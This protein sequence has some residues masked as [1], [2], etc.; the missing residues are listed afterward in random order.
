VTELCDLYLADAE[1]GRLLTQRK[2]SKKP[3]TLATDR[4][5]IERHIKLLL[6]RLAALCCTIDQ[7]GVRNLQN[8]LKSC[9]ERYLVG[10]LQGKDDQEVGKCV[11]ASPKGRGLFYPEGW[12]AGWLAAKAEAQ[13]VSRTARQSGKCM[14]E[15]TRAHDGPVIF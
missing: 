1:A 14:G 9:A 12:V 8:I 10:Y 4:G 2:A 13:Q 15:E 11:D 3:S 6:G 7:A 5:R